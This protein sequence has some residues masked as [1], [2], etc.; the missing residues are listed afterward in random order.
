MSYSLSQHIEIESLTD[1]TIK[2]LKT[3]STAVFNI[4]KDLNPKNTKH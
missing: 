3:N 4:T 1:L 2:K